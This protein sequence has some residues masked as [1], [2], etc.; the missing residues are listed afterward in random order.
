MAGFD[1]FSP[2]SEGVGHDCSCVF[3]LNAG[4]KRTHRS[5]AFSRVVE[6]AEHHVVDW[7]HIGQ[8]FAIGSC[9]I[10]VMLAVIDW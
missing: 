10:S 4:F 2:F 8:V 5:I 7:H 1:H 6:R 3:V 9:S